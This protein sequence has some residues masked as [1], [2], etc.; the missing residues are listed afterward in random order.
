MIRIDT[1]FS[2]PPMAAVL[3]AVTLLAGTVLAGCSDFL[4]INDD[5]NNASLDDIEGE[6]GLLFITAAAAFS[7]NKT[8]EISGTS[9]FAQLWSASNGAAVF[10]NPEL[11]QISTNTTGNTWDAVYTDV[12]Q[13]L[14][15]ILQSADDP[16][17]PLGNPNVAA[18]AK[19][20]KAYGFFYLTQL[21]EEIPF[22]QSNNRDEFPT[23]AFDSQEEVLNGVVALLDEAI[24]QVD[25][26]DGAPAGITQEDVFYGGDMQQ[27]LRFANTVKMKAL[28]LLESGG[29]DVDAALDDAFAG[30]LIRDNADNFEFPYSDNAGNENNWFQVLADFSNGAMIWYDCDAALVDRMLDLGDPRLGTY[31]GPNADGDFV[32]VPSGTFASFV[33]PVAS[34][35]SLNIVRAD[36]PERFATAAEV[37]LLEAEW[38]AKKGNLGAADALYRDGI[39]ASIDWFDAQP[40]AIDDADRDAYL[41]SLPDLATL[42]QADAVEAVQLQQWFDVFERRPESWTH[43]R[44]TKVPALEA[45]SNAQLGGVIRRYPYPPDPVARNTNTPS[46][47]QGD[48][49]MW[50]E[51]GS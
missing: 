10:T 1:L 21:F 39:A 14:N 38:E 13:N 11:Y 12:A 28:V 43:W 22:S 2:R 50:F 31:C 5:P 26:S 27:W 46:P 35:V 7:S 29:A 37:F 18:Q 34:N 6:P 41:A 23:P 45:P 49:P 33:S 47:R 8:V 30:D 17:S 3:L 36:F 40:G 9:S 44:R 42:A 4:D 48:V 25:L 16:E 32:G 20:F 15:F 19:I 24:D 51:G